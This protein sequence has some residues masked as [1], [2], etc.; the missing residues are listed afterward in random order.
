MN[1]LEKLYHSLL[2]KCHLLSTF[3]REPL[4]VDPHGHIDDE[5]RSAITSR[6]E[7]ARGPKLQGGAPMYIVSP[8]DRGGIGD[9]L[10]TVDPMPT[11]DA[12]K[13]PEIWAP[14]FSQ[15][16]PEWVVLTRTIALAGKSR[17]FLV[18]KL[19]NFTGQGG[20]SAAFQETSTSFQA[21][22][23]LLRVNAEL[24]VD[25]ASSSTGTDLSSSA[26]ATA[27]TGSIRELHLGPKKLRLKNYRNMQ[28]DEM[29]Q[30]CHGWRP[31]DALVELL[32]QRFGSLA[33]FFYNR[34]CPDVVAVL[35][36]PSVVSN[37][38]FSVMGS[39][40][41]QPCMEEN[42]KADTMVALN[43]RD[44]LR[45][46]SQYWEGIVVKTKV[47]QG[48]SQGQK[49]RSAA[50]RQRTISAELESEAN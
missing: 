18:S 48:T 4:I 46:M 26:E 39:E 14:G 1:L 13:V 36:R 9:N 10:D 34:L 45:E 30:V 47:F 38:P 8:N 24:I 40:H 6:F 5:D 42:W 35:W 31:V 33:L 23:A 12:G 20:W 28:D 21:Y 17:A 7:Q 27:Y 25:T 41:V 11:E 3:V 22:N 32:R 37:Q 19:T 29:Q 16:T 15:T 44:V 43:V 2:L 49:D 50:K